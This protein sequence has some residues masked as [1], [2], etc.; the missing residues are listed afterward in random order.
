MPPRPLSPHL[1][2]YKFKYTLT[3]S[4]LNRV[5]VLAL[6]MGLLL[7]V[8]WLL[9]V[10]ACARTAAGAGGVSSHRPMRPRHSVGDF[11]VGQPPAQGAGQAH[12]AAAP[13]SHAQ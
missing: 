11:A 12:G 5:A 8:D 6:S 9:A 2:V 4:I 13:A 7:L 3:T 10:A 1:S